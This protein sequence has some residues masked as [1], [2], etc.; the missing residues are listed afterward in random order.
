MQLTI[1][2]SGSQLL[3]NSFVFRFKSK[4]EFIL[5]MCEVEHLKK[6]VSLVESETI[7]LNRSFFT[8]LLFKT[9]DVVNGKSLVKY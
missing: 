9:C 3:F 6:N 7:L 1:V 5:E 2:S 8:Q 4:N